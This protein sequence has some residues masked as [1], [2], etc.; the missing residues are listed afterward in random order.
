MNK[1]VTIGKLADALSKAQGEM[2]GALKES[3]NPFFKSKY[4]SLTSIWNCAK[5]PLTKNQLSVVQ[6]TYIDG[7]DIFLETVLMHASGEWISSVYP[8]KPVK[9]D[10][11]G[12]GS[13]LTYARRYSLQSLLGIVAD[14][15]DDGNEASHR[16]SGPAPRPAPLPDL[17]AELNRIHSLRKELQLTDDVFKAYLQKHF[18]Y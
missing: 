17:S 4:S 10:P 1:S 8:I 16:P 7:G 11:Q 15:D 3:T 13:A 9:Q 5:G 18:N 6:S 2:E 14:D 12:L